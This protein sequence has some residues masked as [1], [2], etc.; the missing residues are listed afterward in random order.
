MRQDKLPQLYDEYVVSLK[1]EAEIEYFPFVSEE[2]LSG[3]ETPA[4]T[5][6]EG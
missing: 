6:S 4:D 3:E 1:D 5:V 2:E